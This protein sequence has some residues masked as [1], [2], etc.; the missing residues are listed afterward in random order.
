MSF[1]FAI[2]SET[3]RIN[4]LVLFRDSYSDNYWDDPGERR[5]YQSDLLS[6]KEHYETQSRFLNLA[7]RGNDSV[8]TGIIYAAPT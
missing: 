2:L 4:L 3:D 1:L 6:A 8:I 5:Y 7:N